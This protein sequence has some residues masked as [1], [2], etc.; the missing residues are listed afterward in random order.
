[1]N[2]LRSSVDEVVACGEEGM[3]LAE[4]FTYPTT[5]PCSVQTS[6]MAFQHDQAQWNLNVQLQDIVT[7]IR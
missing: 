2:R 7:E 5:P 1:L 4:R 6:P 3:V